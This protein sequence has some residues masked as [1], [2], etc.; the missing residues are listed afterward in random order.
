MHSL[1]LKRFFQ[2]SVAILVQAA[3]LF[4]SSGRLDWAMAWAYLGIGVAVVAINALILLPRNLELVAER[5]QIVKEGV[6]SWD[7]QLA[8]IHGVFGPAAT[9]IVAGLDARFGWSPQLGLIVQCGA[10]VC[11]ALGYGLCSWA[12]ASNRFFSCLVRIQKERGHT[13]ITTGPYRIVR[14]PGYLGMAMFSLA[15]P[16]MLGSLWALI[17]AGLTVCVLIVRTVLEDR[18]LQEELDGYT[19]YARHVRFRLLPGVW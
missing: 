4:I 14:H 18:T 1:V 13:V 8:S 16:L 12:L 2:I 6:K 17:P 11:V 10:L 7:K 9:L 15:T 5:A 3:L 19:D